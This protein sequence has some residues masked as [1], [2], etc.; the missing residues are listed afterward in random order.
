[1]VNKY[2]FQDING[3]LKFVHYGDKDGLKKLVENEL[4]DDKEEVKERIIKQ[5]ADGEKAIKI[6]EET[7]TD[8]ELVKLENGCKIANLKKG[9]YMA[10]KELER[11]SE[12]KQHDLIFFEFT[13]IDLKFDNK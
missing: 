13:P 1:M 12:I 4:K 5:I 9:I 10:K 3:E 11:V 2:Y 6:L 8:D 7:Q